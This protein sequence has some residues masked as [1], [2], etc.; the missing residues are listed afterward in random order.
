MIKFITFLFAI[1]FTLWTIKLYYKLY[2]KKI[3][4]YVLNVT[5]IRSINMSVVNSCLICIGIELAF[6]LNLIPNNS[7]YIDKFLK[8]N[9]DMAIVSNDVK[10]I[11]T[12]NNFLVIANQI[13]PF[14][15]AGVKPGSEVTVRRYSGKANPDVSRTTI[16]ATT[17]AGQ[18]VEVYCIPYV[19]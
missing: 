18:E 5:Y 3:R 19:A 7:K 13:V 8:S 15:A 9:L 4:W 17:A 1:I 10:T 6:Y 2:D 12:T 11:Y 14:T 16:N